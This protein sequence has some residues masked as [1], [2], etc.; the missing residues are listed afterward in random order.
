MTEGISASDLAK[1]LQALSLVVPVRKIRPHS[2]SK[3]NQHHRASFDEGI[4]M[5]KPTVELQPRRANRHQHPPSDAPES[6]ASV[7]INVVVLDSPGSMSQAC[8]RAA[9]GRADVIAGDTYLSNERD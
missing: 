9:G 4:V 5:L 2:T 8:C 3:R 6:R 1:R 7:L